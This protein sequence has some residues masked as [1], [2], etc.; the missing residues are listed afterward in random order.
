MAPSPLS[1]LVVDDERDTA[2]SLA[3]LLRM[4]GHPAESAYDVSSALSFARQCSPYLVFLDLPVPDVDGYRL[5]EQLRRLP[6]MK[7]AVLV[8]TSGYAGSVY[9][10][11][12]RRVGFNYFLMKPID[13]EGVVRLVGE[14]AE[15]RRER[16][17]RKARRKEPLP[18]GTVRQLGWA[19]PSPFR[20]R[21][22]RR[23]TD[24]GGP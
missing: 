20:G 14:L 12:A 15:A 21:R 10:K 5:A 17:E 1:I 24:L 4:S 3:M 19:T 11:R 8:C 2:D 23:F 18:P 16:F 9:Q 6:G 7:D 13:P 22:C